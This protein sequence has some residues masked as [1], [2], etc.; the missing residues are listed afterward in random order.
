MVAE[1]GLPRPMRIRASLCIVVLAG[2]VLA[3]GGVPPRPASAPDSHALPPPEVVL[4][5]REARIAARSGRL[6]EALARLETLVAAHPEAIEA[7]AAL[8]ELKV[9]LGVPA[10][11]LRPLWNELLDLLTRPG[12]LP[13]PVLAERL[14]GRFWRDEEA[15][16]KLARAMRAWARRRPD[17]L[18]LEGLL[19][20][21]LGRIGA[22]EE[23]FAR[24]RARAERARGVIE[25][26]RA[27]DAA[28][29]A[30]D[31]EG[32]L[33]FA[34]CSDPDGFDLRDEML[35]LHALVELGRFDQARSLLAE[36]WERPEGGV[37]L[38]RSWALRLA[39]RAWDGGGREFSEDLFRRLAARYPGDG[40]LQK[41]VLHLFGDAEELAAARAEQASRMAEIGDPFELV[42]QA[43][44]QLAAGDAAGAWPLLERAVERAPEMTV[45]WQNL[46]IAAIQLERWD[47]ARAAL[48]IV[49][50]GN[51]DDTMA[52]YNSGLVAVRQQDWRRAVQDLEH[53]LTLDPAAEAA[54][55]YLYKAWQG[56]GDAAKAGEHLRAYE[57]SRKGP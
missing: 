57:A 46:A 27:L 52:L 6:D 18:A 29:A 23:A 44:T 10:S 24:A 21:L 47:R 34:P 53:L 28:L 49:L 7:R 42:Q 25:C 14:I 8:L 31:W 41:T 4:A 30:E 2:P 20:E 3:A 54:H 39:W 56:L 22:R 13:R 11:E 33:E 55:Y 38:M 50:A 45:A 17:D 51:P 32:V 37:N 40:P 9:D 15:L 35:R 26:T 1:P 48:D 19:L 5:Q 36:T 16:R 43:A 12:S